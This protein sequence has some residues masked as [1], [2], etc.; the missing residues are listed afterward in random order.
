MLPFA[1]RIASII[2][3]I[4]S[5]IALWYQP[6]VYQHQPAPAPGQ[7]PRPLAS[8]SSPPCHTCSCTLPASRMH[9]I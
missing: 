7:S 5:I 4:T 1:I 6:W 9:L 2:I 8:A 3:V